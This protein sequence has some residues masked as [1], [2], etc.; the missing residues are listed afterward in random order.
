[1]GA[2]D[3]GL[4]RMANTIFGTIMLFV[5]IGVPVAIVKYV[6]E[7]RDNDKKLEQ[8]VSAGLITSFLLGLFSFIFI[9]LSAGLWRISLICLNFRP[10]EDSCFCISFLYC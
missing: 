8:I 4:Y 10:T 3:L 6:A 9:Y 1:M 2:D 7:F 5:T